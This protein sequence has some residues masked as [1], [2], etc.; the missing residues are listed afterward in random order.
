M[1]IERMREMDMERIRELLFCLEK[2][3][4]IIKYRLSSGAV[5]TIDITEMI[6]NDDIDLIADILKDIPFSAKLEAFQ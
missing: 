2:K 1:D 5:I 6:G 3:T 4:P